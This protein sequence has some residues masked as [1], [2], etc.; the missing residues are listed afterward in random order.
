M[1]IVCPQCSTTNRIPPERV[2]DQPVC[3]RCGAE[4]L[5]QVPV[6]LNDATFARYIERT[7]A[8][9]LVDFWAAWCGPCKVMA[10]QFVAA[11]A[12]TPAVR[13]VKV[14]TEAAPRTSQHYAIRSIP[15]L[16]I[17]VAGREVDRKSGVVSAAELINWLKA[18]I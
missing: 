2:H 4:V 18:T 5:P 12:Q 1:N 17:F 15:T 13:F 9:V 8:P 10:P 16:A 3:G 7:E 11:A 6:E 14:D